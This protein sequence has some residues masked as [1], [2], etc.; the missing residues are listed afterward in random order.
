MPS[1][2][3]KMQEKMTAVANTVEKYLDRL[4]PNNDYAER[5][6]FEA[7]RYACLGGGKRLRAFLCVSSA[8]MFNV[9]EECSYRVAAALEMFHAYSLVHDDM[10]EMDNS[11]TRRGKPS[12]H[13][14]FDAATALLAGDALQAR[15]FEILADSDTHEDP[16]VRIGLVECLGKAAG[17]SGM[18]AGQMLDMQSEQ[19]E[20][21]IG[22]ITRLQRLKTG[23]LISA[24]AQM[25]AIL[26]KGSAPQRHA[27]AS[28]GYDIGLAF[29]IIDDVLDFSGNPQV[30][31][32]PVL[33]DGKKANFVTIMGLERAQQQAQLLVEKAIGYLR[34]F[35]GRNGD[36]A[37][38]ARFI[39]Q[40]DS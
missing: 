29:Q 13:K 36:L 26:G 32:K 15:A 7:M 9:S 24:A 37:D 6:L 16:R 25:G 20:F 19:T 10:P 40:R 18:C 5:K 22:T 33:K 23:E 12:T 28:Y 30:M 38:V 11:D 8:R 3:P 31:G 35:D 4:L 34:V 27:L 14:Q 17:M 1:V 21:D 39:V 2:D